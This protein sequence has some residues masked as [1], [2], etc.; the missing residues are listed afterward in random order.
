V[1]PSRARSEKRLTDVSHTFD[2]RNPAVY[3]IED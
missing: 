3:E 1:D 2:D